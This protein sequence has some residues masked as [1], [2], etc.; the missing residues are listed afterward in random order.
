M[1]EEDTTASESRLV[2]FNRTAPRKN[3]RHNENVL[4]GGH[5][6]SNGQSAAELAARS[7]P[8]VEAADGGAGGDGSG[9][10]D[11]AGDSDPS[12]DSDGE[13][14]ENAGGSSRAVSRLAG[15]SSRAVPRLAG[16]S[17]RAASRLAAARQL[18]S[19]NGANT[20]SRP[21]S[22]CSSSADT[23]AAGKPSLC[24]VPS[25]KPCPVVGPR[26]MINVEQIAEV[27]LGLTEDMMTENGG[28]G[29]ATV[30]MQALSK[31]LAAVNDNP[32]AL[33]ELL[34]F[35]GNSKSGARAIA[36]GRH[37]SSHGIRVVASVLG[38][39]HEEGLLDGVRRQLNVFRNSGGTA[40]PWEEVLSKAMSLEYQP[41]L[42]IDGLLGIHLGLGD[43]CTDHR[44]AVLKMV[45][46]A[47]NSRAQVLS[48]D[49][50]SGIDGNT[51]ISLPS[52]SVSLSGS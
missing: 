52:T 36:A 20:A 6:N 31:R 14:G 12:G 27:E 40:V 32:N 4:D 30:A 8:A 5:P 21:S 47:N 9:D 25:C 43:L 26:Q 35:A 34:V 48:I 23:D 24:L 46:F 38:L 16:G 49:V 50:P 37:L 33:G 42:I 39:E 1:Q 11:G 13:D 44:I 15:G 10:G 19:S 17:S 7:W 29:I 28:R 45:Q 41:E 51:G 3:Y 2:S 22:A 18:G